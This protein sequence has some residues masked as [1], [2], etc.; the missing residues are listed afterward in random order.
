[1][2]LEKDYLLFTSIE[3][4]QNIDA[5]GEVALKVCPFELEQCRSCLYFT[6]PI[7]RINS[8]VSSM[9]RLSCKDKQCSQTASLQYRRI[10]GGRNLA[11]VRN[12]VVAAIFDFMTVEDWGE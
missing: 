7:K 2:Y 6:T 8:I 3:M 10:L 11:R 12:I 1:M 4:T 9:P 5:G